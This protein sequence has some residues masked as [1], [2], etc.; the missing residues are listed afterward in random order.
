[1]F[2]TF[3]LSYTYELPFGKGK[4]WG[5]WLI[6]GIHRYHVPLSI[7]VNNTLPVFSRAL[8]AECGGRRATAEFPRGG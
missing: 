6:G 1:M 7:L 2:R 3:V 4:R 5:G 8:R